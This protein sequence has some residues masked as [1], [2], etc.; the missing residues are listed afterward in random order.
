MFHSRSEGIARSSE[1]R[2]RVHPDFLRTQEII[3]TINIIIS[4][5]CY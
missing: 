2:H 1:K 3:S 4:R 5:E